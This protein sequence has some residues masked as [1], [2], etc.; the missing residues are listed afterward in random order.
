MNAAASDMI[1]SAETSSR[2]IE[3][4]CAAADV[5]VGTVRKFLSR[6]GA[7]TP[8]DKSVPP[9][10]EQLQ[11]S[12][13]L[14][15]EG[16]A[17]RSAAKGARQE[18]KQPKP[19]P[20]AAG[21]GR[22]PSE[23]VAATLAEGHNDT[24]M[25]LVMAATMVVSWQNMYA[26]TG[27]L[28]A[29]NRVASLTLTGLLCLSPFVFALCGMVSGQ[30]KLLIIALG[31]FEAFCN[32]ARIY[33]GLTNFDSPKAMGWPTRFLGLVTDIFGSGT[34][35][36]ALALSFLLSGLIFW[37]FYTALFGLKK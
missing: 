21:A 10:A 28:F 36:T 25:Y 33:G 8:F 19:R 9:T 2:T 20:N 5:K 6:R 4:I 30:V 37:L 15:G 22:Q 27:E 3:E 17:Q 23:P 34:S 32:I 7:V 26:V 11:F 31:V 29:E 35:G 18:P 12:A 24:G 14:R 1:G 13:V 16:S